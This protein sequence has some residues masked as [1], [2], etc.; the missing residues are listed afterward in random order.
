LPSSE[1]FVSMTERY[2]AQIVVS[3]DVP[4]GLVVKK[5]FSMN[6]FLMTT[7]VALL[8]GTAPAI[9]AEESLPAGN[10]PEAGALPTE[11]G[12]SEDVAKQATE[13]SDGTADTSGGAAERSS[14]P[15]A[16]G[17]ASVDEDASKAAQ[18]SDTSSGAKEQSSAPEG[19]SAADKSKPNPTIGSESSSSKDADTSK[20]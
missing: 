6:R 9:A 4:I 3:S 8:I 2:P 12:V 11:P 19:S 17:A 7:A 14:A 16:S 10:P 13:P 1:K 18:S 20:E 5:E 15:P